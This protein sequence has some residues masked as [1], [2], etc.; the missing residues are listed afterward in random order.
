MSFAL[1]VGR[2]LASEFVETQGGQLISRPLGRGEKIAEGMW[3][4]DHPCGCGSWRIFGAVVSAHIE[5]S[6]PIEFGQQGGG[7][8]AG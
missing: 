1:L 6:K 4:R 2:A 5:G 8:G 3:V 7:G